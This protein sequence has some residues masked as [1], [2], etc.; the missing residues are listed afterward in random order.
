M[1]FQLSPGVN[2]TEI[3]LTTVIPAVATTDAAIG[4]VFR[5]GPVDKPI[6]VTSEDDLVNKFGKP[7]NLNPETFFT[8]ASY[9]AYS[10]SLYVSRAFSEE[11]YSQLF[12]ATSVDATNTTVTVA[13]ADESVFTV[14]DI[15]FGESIPTGTTIVSVSNA[16]SVTDI[17][18]SA[19]P[20]S[21]AS[22]DLSIFDGA[23]SFNAVANSDGVALHLHNVRNEEHYEEK[24]DNFQSACHYIARY[25]GDL[26]NSMAISVCPTSAA[27]SR[28]VVL[29]D[30]TGGDGKT[31]NEKISF[32]VGSANATISIEANTAAAGTSTESQNAVDEVLGFLSVGDKIKAGNSTVGFQYME[33]KSI[34]SSTVAGD[35]AT[36]EIEFTDTFN[37]AGAVDQTTLVR[38]W[39]FWDVVSGAPGQSPY[40]FAQ[41]NTSAQDEMHVVVYDEDGKITGNPGTILE[42][43]DRVSRATD[44]KNADAGSN[45][46]KDVINQSSNWVYY[47]EDISTATSATSADLASST[48]GNPK[49]WSFVGGR[50]V[51]DETNSGCSIG[52]VI[53]AYEHFKSAED[54]DIS[55][56]L[57]GKSRGGGV[58]AQLGNWLVDNIAETRKDCVVFMSPEKGDVVA[59]AGGTEED[60]VVNFRNQCRSTSYAVL[61]SGY[62]YMYDKYNDV[63]RWIPLNGDIAGLAARTDDVRDPWFSPAG[64]NRGQIKNVVKLAWNPKKAERDLLYKNGINPV[65]NF[66]GQGIVLFGD[67]TLLAK[68]SAFDRINVRRLFI[69]L[70]KAIATAAK[71]TLFEFNDTFTR[72]SFVNLVEPYLRD[73][74]GR[75]GITD[76]V[77]VCDETNNTGEVIDRNEFIGD[78]YIKPAR[79]INFIQ[80]NFVAVR[81]G[82]EFSEVIGNF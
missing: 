11:G 56:I 51:G 13:E 41:G 80:L 63:Y 15:V 62:K 72:A 47:A 42:V 70:E 64:F 8:A 36:A 30:T 6:L 71:F 4:G 53:A 17:E 49:A 18:L 57:T 29:A 74:Q 37:Q 39:Q 77:V 31:E 25:Q 46:V 9:L 61:D 44:A 50:D 20:T 45:Y 24:E 82:V 75:R 3:D 33:I 14:G 48:S 34:G 40:Q 16:G 58:G 32:T 69:V 5:W 66:P 7:S 52:R 21:S 1:P 68:P 35:D 65:V 22:V 28:S 43:W 73:V 79:S 78:I 26:G 59:N 12:T 27:F 76:F 23:R 67:K 10:D 55:L 19:L 60:D 38:Y 2:V 81:T 54:I